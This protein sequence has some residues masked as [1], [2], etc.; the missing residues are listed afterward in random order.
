MELRT[1]LLQPLK[2][3]M[4]PPYQEIGGGLWYDIKLHPIVIIF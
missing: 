2:R 4:I 3:M 1:Y